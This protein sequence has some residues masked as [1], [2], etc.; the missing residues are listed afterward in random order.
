MV[1][2]GTNANFDKFDTKY[3]KGG[4]E[5]VSKF[6]TNKEAAKEY[7]NNVI[8]VFLR[9]DDVERGTKFTSKKGLAKWFMGGKTFDKARLDLV[10]ESK[11]S[12]DANGGVIKDVRSNDG[13]HEM[14]VYYTDSNDNIGFVS[15]IKTP[16][17]NIGIVGKVAKALVK[18]LTGKEGE[19][20]ETKIVD[21]DT[22]S[23]FNRY[24]QKKKELAEK[25]K[26]E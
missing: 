4:A 16:K 6:T 21:K 2:H 25:E 17:Q 7:G 26:L 22:P 11:K 14:D 10:Y 19:V 1:Y 5:R 18:E 3:T 15:D 20:G 12:E 9:I 24:N 23:I 8:E 13:K